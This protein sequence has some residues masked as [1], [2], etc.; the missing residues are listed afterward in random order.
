MAMKPSMRILTYKKY[1]PMVASKS[2]FNIFI[3]NKIKFL[4]DEMIQIKKNIKEIESLFDHAI[5]KFV[6][7]IIE[8]KKDAT[9]EEAKK[10][11]TIEEAKKDADEN[12]SIMDKILNK[13]PQQFFVILDELL[14]KIDDK[15]LEKIE[16]KNGEILMKYTEP[17]DANNLK[18]NVLLV[19][20]EYI[21]LRKII[22]KFIN[23]LKIEIISGQGFGAIL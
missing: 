6:I 10:D 13:N 21:N 14:W 20:D 16:Q 11:A 12:Q 8:A 19:P 2:E 22:N 18:G 7:T 5:N 1:K 15:N 23:R 3:V 4:A 9:I 17:S